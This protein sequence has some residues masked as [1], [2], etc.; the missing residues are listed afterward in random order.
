MQLLKN[1]HVFQGADTFEYKPI[2]MQHYHILKVRNLPITN[3]NGA[4]ICIHSERM[5]QYI[6]IPYDNDPGSYNSIVGTIEK[7]AIKNGFN[8]IGLGESKDGFYFVTDTFK[9][10]K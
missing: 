4:R 9:P 3:H 5:K 8:L 10:L 6:I 2:N 1:V 7:W